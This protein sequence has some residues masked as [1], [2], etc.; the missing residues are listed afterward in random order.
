MTAKEEEALSDKKNRFNKNNNKK[1]EEYKTYLAKRGRPS[2]TVK[3]SAR[4]WNSVGET[5]WKP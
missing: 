1:V 5:W 4:T 2:G 3:L